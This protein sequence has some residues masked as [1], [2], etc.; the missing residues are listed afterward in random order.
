MLSKKLCLFEKE[1]NT[2]PHPE[3]ITFRHKRNVMFTD[4]YCVIVCFFPYRFQMTN[5]RAR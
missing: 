2:I 4:L 3:Q 1:I 5:I